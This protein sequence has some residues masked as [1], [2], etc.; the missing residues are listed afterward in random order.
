MSKSPGN[1]LIKGGTLITMDKARKVLKGDILVEDGRIS[2]IGK[3]SASAG[4][5]LILDAEGKAVLPGFIQT[6]VHLCQTLLRGMAEDMPL[7]E[8]LK[9]VIWPGEAAMDDRSLEA[10]VELG[11]CEVIRSGTTTIQ[12]MGTVNGQDV[13]FESLKRSNIRAFAGKAMMDMGRGVP[14]K[15]KETTRNS[16]QTS[17]ALCKRWNG[18]NNGLVRYAFAPRFVLSCSSRLLSE[19]GPI[20]RENKARIHTH[21]SEQAPE[22]AA[23]KRNYGKDNVEVLAEFGLLGEDVGLAHCVHVSRK[24]IRLLAQTGTGVLHCPSANLKLGSGIAPVPEMDESGVRLSLGADG[25]PCNNNLNPFNEM[26]LASLIQKARLGPGA[27]PAVNALALATIRGAEVLGLEHETGSIEEGKSA[28]LV[29]VDLGKA[30]NTGHDLYSSLV[31]ASNRDDVT[32]V[33][34][35]G[36]PLLWQGELMTLDEDAIVKKAE[37]EKKR[38]TAEIDN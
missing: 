27:M 2:K 36:K 25:A 33:I 14:R 20:A 12:D 21:C 37:Q 9:K 19:I 8:W 3:V 16:L 31:F 38:L 5:K 7:L 29:V 32:H 28:D 24:E 18:A 1:M 11:L 22:V 15:L 6:H 30:H 35:A 23:V 26:R 17:E 10:S 34:V 4:G 13:V